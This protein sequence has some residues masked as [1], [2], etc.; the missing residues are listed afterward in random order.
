MTPAKAG[1]NGFIENLKS[2]AG[3]V[4]IFLL[5]RIFLFQPFTIPSASM[6]PLLRN[7]DYIVVTKFDYGFSR[8]SIPFSPPLFTGRLFARE[9]RRGDVIVFRVP[10]ANNVDYIKRVIGLPGDEVQVREGKLYLNDVL[11]RDVDIGAA[12]TQGAEPLSVRR[13]RETLPEGRSFETFDA[14]YTMGDNTDVFVVPAGHYFFMG[15]NRD[16]SL[17]SRFTTDSGGVGLVPAE[18]LVGRARIIVMSWRPQASLLKPWTWFTQAEPSRFLK[19]L[20]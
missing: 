4:A 19:P 20:G 11:V 3:V 9:P 18:R 13:I 16:N 8:Y 10:T 6:E 2:L 7:G 1:E 15:D 17:D 12:R 14:G 5:I